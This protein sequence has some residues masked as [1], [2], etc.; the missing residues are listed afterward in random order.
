MMQQ[1]LIKFKNHQYLHSLDTIF[2]I[3]IKPCTRI[4]LSPLIIF[5]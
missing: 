5:F 4:H 3:N 2:I 1:K